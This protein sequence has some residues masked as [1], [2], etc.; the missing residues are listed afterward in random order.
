MGWNVL[1]LKYGRK[2][3]AAFEREGGEALRRWIDDC[4]NSLYSALTFPGR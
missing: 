4:P 2:L 1:T 3:Q